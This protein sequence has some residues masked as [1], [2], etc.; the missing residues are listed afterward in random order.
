[1]RR[2]QQ[3]ANWCLR[4]SGLPM[5]RKGSP[6][7]SWIMRRMRKAFLRSF[8][9]HQARSSTAAGSSSKFRA[10]FLKRNPFSACLRLQKPLAHRLALEQIRGLAFRFDFPPEFNRY[11]YAYGFAFGVRDIVHRLLDCH[12]FLPCRDVSTR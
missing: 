9:T 7:I 6:W 12:G 8:S 2:E 1:M 11:E 10:D 5:P 4:G 3:P